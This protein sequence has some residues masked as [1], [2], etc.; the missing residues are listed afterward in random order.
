M[1]LL[2]FWTPLQSQDIHFSQ[3]WNNPLGIN[4]ALT[5]VNKQD[6]RIFGAYKRQWASVPVGYTTFSGAFDT[7]WAPFK[8]RTGYF[9][10]G[11]Q[12]NNDQAGDSDWTLAD[13]T[14]SIAYTQQLSR[15]FFATV[16]GQIG[17]GHRS[18]KLEQLTFDNQFNGEVFDP[19]IAPAESFT[20]TATTFL[21]T[22]F[23]LNLHFQKNDK[24]TKLDVGLGLHHLN[25]PSQNFYGNSTIDIPVRKDI[26]AMG[27]LKL[28]NNFDLLGNGLLRMQGEYQEIVLGAALRIHLNTTQT[29]ELALDLGGNW[30][31]GD[32]ISPYIGLI[33]H[34][35]RFGFSYDIN[36]SPFTT[37]TNS[38]GGPEVIAIYTITKLRALGNKLCPLF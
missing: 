25:T 31:T 30:R 22:G 6:I 33:Y 17:I 11:A 21:D 32:A 9:G 38:N 36:T 35:W 23:G 19:S 24:R 26:Y 8:S 7:K 10:L 5:G 3:Y 16:G 28:N 4:P 12:F 37:A 20:N 15:G 14:G 34:Q 29:K 27:V 1:I 18:F 13:F 2:L